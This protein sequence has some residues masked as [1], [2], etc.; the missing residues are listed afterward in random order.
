MPFGESAG[1][2]VPAAAAAAAEATTKPQQADEPSGRLLL[3]WSSFGCVLTLWLSVHRLIVAISPAP[4]SPH[5]LL[6]H[7][8]L[9]IVLVA[10]DADAAAVQSYSVGGRPASFLR[11]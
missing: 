2:V 3:F 7:N 11:R 9:S 5:A 8:G 4:S 1:D 10:A 6:I